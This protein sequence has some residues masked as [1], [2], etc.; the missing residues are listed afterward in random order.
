MSGPVG[1][2]DV[3]ILFRECVCVG[4]YIDYV[5]CLCFPTSF[6]FS[7]RV[8]AY[9]RA[10]SHTSSLI[11]RTWAST[12]RHITILLISVS[13]ATSSVVVNKYVCVWCLFIFKNLFHLSSVIEVASGEYGDLNP[14]LFEAVQDGLCSEESKKNSRDKSDSSCPSQCYSVS[15]MTQL[16]VTCWLYSRAE[17]NSSKLCVWCFCCLAVNTQL[18]PLTGAAPVCA[19]CIFVCGVVAFSVDRT[20]LTMC[21]QSYSAVVSETTEGWLQIERQS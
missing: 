18:C 9:T 13:L 3:H 19:A 16:Q 11:W 2:P 15:T 4:N 21:N 10:Q 5:L 20:L 14:V 8:S 7:V 17:L 12:A 6:T 1:L